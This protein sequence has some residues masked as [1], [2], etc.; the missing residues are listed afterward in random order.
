MST[1]VV[2]HVQRFSF[3][4]AC[5]SRG[6]LTFLTAI[7]YTYGPRPP[8]HIYARIGYLTVIFPDTRRP[9]DRTGVY[10]TDANSRR[11][12]RSRT[13]RTPRRR[14]S[15]SR[16]RERRGATARRERM[17][18]RRWAVVS[19]PLRMKFDGRP[20]IGRRCGVSLDKKDS[21]PPRRTPIS[22]GIPPHK[23]PRPT[24][25]PTGARPP[26]ALSATLSPQIPLRALRCFAYN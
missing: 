8:R 19:I 7:P 26:N 4:R 22:I 13:T 18:D 3:R 9:D 1:R 20:T 25:S 14:A 24:A 23:P 17:P 6:W 11:S 5:L 15:A 2:R 12:R 16:G 21:P 10:D